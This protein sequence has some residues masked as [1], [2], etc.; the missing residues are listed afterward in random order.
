MNQTISTQ[1]SPH[2][3]DL[4]EDFEDPTENFPAY[5]PYAGKTIVRNCGVEK[6][7]FSLPITPYTRTL[8]S[9]KEAFVSNVFKGGKRQSLAKKVLLH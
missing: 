8:E 4:T 9:F 1:S 3:K 5:F 2:D 6:E 7:A